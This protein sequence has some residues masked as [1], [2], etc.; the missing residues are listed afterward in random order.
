MTSGTVDQTP[1]TSAP[2]AELPLLAEP[3]DGVPEVVETPEALRATIAALRAGTGPIAIDTERAQGFR[4]SGRAY[5]VQFRRTDAGTHL[6]D[7]SPFVDADDHPHLESVN[8]AIADQ[9]WILHAATQDLPCLVDAGLVPTRLF[10]T[11]LAARLLGLPRVALATLIEEFFGLRLKK[12]HSAADWSKR[13][14]P[15]DWLVYAALDVELLVD[16]RDRLEARLREADKLEWAEQEFAHLVANA[17]VPPVEKRDRWRRTTG[18]HAVKSRRG[19]AIVRELWTERD[20]LGRRLDRAAGRILPDQGIADLAALARDGRGGAGGVAPTRA[21]IRRIPGFARRTARQYE[22]N[23][24]AALER[25]VALPPSQLPPTRMPVD[26]P[27]APRS[28]PGRHPEP[29]ARWEALRP[30]TNQIAE[31]H[32]LPPEN[33]VSPDVLRRFCWE[34]K[35][36][37]VTAESVGARLRALSA[38]P[39]QVELLAGRFAEALAQLG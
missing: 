15:H 17:T 1:P 35:L 10:D 21:D 28:W 19:L 2:P 11:E 37:A 7:P 12:E 31:D 26:G 8:D 9:E 22:N 6:V 39:W 23:W 20:N 5:L 29:A 13:P 33:L 27:P 36:D 16:L 14:L 34:P 30:L 25:A 24:I 18:M 38:R 32:E 4:Y 3:A